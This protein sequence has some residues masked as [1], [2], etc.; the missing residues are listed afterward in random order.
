[1]DGLNSKK[2]VLR[3]I[4]G[5]SGATIKDLPSRGQMLLP[6]T[7]EAQEISGFIGGSPNYRNVEL[8]KRLGEFAKR[9]GVGKLDNAL[10]NQLV[11]KFVQSGDLG[12]LPTAQGNALRTLLASEERM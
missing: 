12:S 6:P 1:M 10:R 2:E 8:K 11:A 3:R 9:I 4:K 7:R 5:M